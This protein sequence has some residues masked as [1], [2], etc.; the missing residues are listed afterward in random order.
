[1]PTNLYANQ[2]PDPATTSSSLF[3]ITPS[4]SAALPKLC[5]RIYVGVSGDVNLIDTKENTVLHKNCSA[6]SYLGDFNVYAVLATG[7]TATN[8]VGYS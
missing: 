1:M 5:R 8:L 3:A 6:G 2:S 7:T 4:D